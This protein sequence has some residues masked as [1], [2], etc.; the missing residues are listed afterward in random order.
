MLSHICGRVSCWTMLHQAV[1]LTQARLRCHLC[2][3]WFSWTKQA[4]AADLVCV[5]VCAC[6]PCPGLACWLAGL[7]ACSEA[8]IARH[9]AWRGGSWPLL[10]LSSAAAL[11][12]RWCALS[13]LSCVACFKQ[14]YAQAILY[15][16]A[17]RHQLL[18]G[19][20]LLGV[21]GGGGMCVQGPPPP[22]L[23]ASLSLSPAGVLCSLG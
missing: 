11:K 5:L 17:R 23:P 19:V 1:V 10:R 21:C 8:C 4:S 13:A 14:V 15:T 22:S 6:L 3:C 18:L 9:E 12:R 7:R 2:L 16:Y 20:Q